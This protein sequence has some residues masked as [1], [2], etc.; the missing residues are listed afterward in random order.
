MDYQ[1]CSRCVMDNNG[2]TDIRFDEN[3]VC[4]YCT[5]AIKRKNIV[6]FP[7]EEGQ[8][9]LQK[10]IDRLK[11]EG[12][13]KKYDCMMGISGGL[14]SSY[15]AMLGAKWGLRILAVHID[16]GFDTEIAKLNIKNLC[17]AC[18]I[19]L[20]VIAP[21]AEQFNG[22]TKAFVLSGSPTLDM[23]QDNV[24]F[25]T[26]H[27]F[28][29]KYKIKYFLSGGNFALESILQRTSSPNAYDT[30]K[31]KHINRKYGETPINKLDIMSNYQRV[32]DKYI[33]GF[34]TIRPLN[35]IEYNKDKAI[36][37]LRDFCGFQYYEAKHCENYLTK[38]VQLYW[39]PKKFNYDKRKSHLSSLIV[40]NQID[41]ES[42]IKEL[43]KAPF[44]V[45]NMEHDLNLVLLKL[46][47][48]RQYFNEI[49]NKGGDLFSD[50][51]TSLSYKIA[52]RLFKN[53]FVKFKG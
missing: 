49:V 34:I 20:E 51:K 17:Q 27:R 32:F 47:I 11:S 19:D 15:L 31:I 12:A 44:D 6:Y 14:D 30:K 4:S 53:F 7:G 37:E 22:L 43:E 45:V 10:L 16:D 2:D 33:Y 21:N 1:R 46:Q 29:K 3:G 42:A 9:K 5:E 25:A 40:T 52:N 41:R 38:V 26:L 24:L 23:P 28:A 39:F 36:E 13:G 35:Y 50:E 18:N 48:E 8:L